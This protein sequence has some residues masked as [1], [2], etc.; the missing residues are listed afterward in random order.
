MF[1]RLSGDHYQYLTA[2][3][4]STLVTRQNVASYGVSE[5]RVLIYHFD[6]PIDSTYIYIM[7]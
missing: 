3:S 1:L 5:S 6:Y 7:Y 2:R 4:E